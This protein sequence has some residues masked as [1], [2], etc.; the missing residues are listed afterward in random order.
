MS[1]M[2]TITSLPVLSTAAEHSEVLLGDA[3][4]IKTATV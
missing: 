3:V 2:A 4:E 1:E